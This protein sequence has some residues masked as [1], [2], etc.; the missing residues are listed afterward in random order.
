MCLKRLIGGVFESSEPL[1]TFGMMGIIAD[2]V[3]T[4]TTKYIL[5]DIQ[6]VVRP[7]VWNGL[8]LHELEKYFCDQ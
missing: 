7:L 1:H 4:T 6:V 2:G 8:L 5:I 3:Y